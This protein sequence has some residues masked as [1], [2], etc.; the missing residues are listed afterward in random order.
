MESNQANQVREKS[1]QSENKLRKLSNSIKY[2]NIHTIVITEE[3]RENGTKNLLEEI[4]TEHFTNLGKKTDI[5]IQDT[6]ETPTK[7]IQ[8]DQCQDT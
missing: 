3:E 2:N 1:I 7:S 8:G 6:Q 4:I 5:W